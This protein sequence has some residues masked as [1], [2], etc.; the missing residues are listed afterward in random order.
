MEPALANESKTN[1]ETDRIKRKAPQK[2]QVGIKFLMMSASIAAT[3]I[4]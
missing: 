1:N 3:M 2:G 4:G